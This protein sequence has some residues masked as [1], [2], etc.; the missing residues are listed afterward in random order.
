M[1]CSIDEAW[2]NKNS[3]DNISKRYQENFNPNITNELN[4][5]KIN[6]NDLEVTQKQP[7][8]IPRQ[9]ARFNSA[10]NTVFN[11]SIIQE[12]DDIQTEDIMLPSEDDEIEHTVIK[13]A[14]K[15]SSDMECTELISKVLSCPKCRK[16]ISEKLQINKNPFHN[17]LNGE[18]REILI[19]IL[20]GLIVM[21]LIDLFIRISK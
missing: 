2:N 19:L 12:S 14:I 9:D 1:Y 5:Y 15:K 21:I 13:P 6:N 18:I 16:L 3:I 8:F 11:E 4:S 10:Q 20:I 7:L 17:L